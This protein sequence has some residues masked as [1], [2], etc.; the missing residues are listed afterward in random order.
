MNNY[1]EFSKFNYFGINVTAFTNKKGEIK[2]DVKAPAEFK[3]K[4]IKH[5]YEPIFQK[6]KKGERIDD[7]IPNGIAVITKELSTIDVDIIEE[8]EI[9]DDLLKDCSFIVKTRKGYHFYFNKEDILPRFEQ[10]EIADINCNTLYYVPKYYH[11]ETNEEFKYEV[12]KNEGDLVDMPLYAIEW[13]KKL[14]EKTNKDKIENKEK[15]IREVKKIDNDEGI[16]ND[17]KS[18]VLYQILDGLQSYRFENFKYWFIIACVF[19]NEKYDLKI[20]DEYSKK[21]KGYDKEANDNI[22]NNLRKTENGYKLA[23]LYF[24]L[25][26][27]NFELWRKLQSERKDFWDFMETFNHYDIASVYYQI[28]PNKYIYSSNQWYSLNNFN[29]Y[30]QLSDY[31]NHLFNNITTT[32][33]NI[34]IEQRNLINPSDESYLAKNKL[35]KKN[36]NNIG[37]STFKKGIIDALCGLYYI[38]NIENKFN[39][40]INVIAFN[41]KL[42]DVKTGK[43]REI[44]PEDYISVT[45][46]Y[47]APTNEIINKY[48]DEINKL[49]YSIF[50]EKEV[51]DYWFTTIG[52][53][54]YGNK[55]E[56]MYIHTGTGRNGK[57]L[58]GN[59]LEKCLGSYYQQADSKLLTG[60]TKGDT[61]PTLANAKYTRLLVLSEPDDTNNKTYKLKTSLVKSI[62]GGDTITVRDLYKSNI[63]YKPKF[64]VVLQCNTKPEIDKL[65][66]A[67]EQ[68]L[69]VIHYPF[70]FTDNPNNENERL[71]DRSLK[72]KL[73][74]DEDFIK[75]FIGILN[76]YAFKNFKLNSIPIPSK[77]KE[78][79]DEYFNENNPVKDFLND[80]CE[81]TNNDKDR[82]DA[83][84][85]YLAYINS[86]RYKTIDEKLFS[87]L[88]T[89]L[90]GIK[91][92]KSGTM[93]YCSLKFN[94][95]PD[96]NNLNEN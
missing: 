16:V 73:S 71:I 25:K 32:I 46:G 82:C 72:D 34:I 28:Y 93:K 94:G 56:S 95:I 81:I 33:Q 53:S 59:I 79:N 86:C 64:N 65:D 19:V 5:Y 50:N 74:N 23:T 11:I 62:T 87:N 42:Y 1:D 13:C 3:Y 40:N 2:K 45:C 67:I 17:K 10:C 60:E 9:L 31:K 68:R 43:Y 35:I 44:T 66:R 22:I 57:G 96:E 91:K 84:D 88:M 58:L 61:C 6:N 21:Y 38:E 48:R 37:N 75:S 18:D 27:D 77:V 7:V 8:C 49:L 26:E 70:T 76:E 92:I 20:F 80:C 69:K 89:N 78:K 29:V 90:N 41:D 15:K 54:L 14:I 83:R 39:D 30:K 4:N 51:V 85:L 52:L 63:S 55:S 47:N 24:M 36:Y 12:F